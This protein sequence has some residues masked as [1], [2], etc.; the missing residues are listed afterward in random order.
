M[1]YTVIIDGGSVT[2]T[3]DY[4]ECPNCKVDIA[5]E[6]YHQRLERTPTIYIKCKNCKTK[7]ALQPNFKG[8]VVAY[9]KKKKQ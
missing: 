2:L 6:D 3:N 7:L 1:S 8:D 4:F 9:I 5:S